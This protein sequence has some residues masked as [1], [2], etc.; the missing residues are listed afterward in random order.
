VT[1]GCAMVLSNM[2]NSNYSRLSE[3]VSAKEWLK[4]K[5]PLCAQVQVQWSACER[6]STISFVRVTHQLVVLSLI[7]FSR[8]RWIIENANAAPRYLSLYLTKFK[9]RFAQVPW[10]LHVG[11]YTTISSVNV[12]TY[13][14]VVSPKTWTHF[15]VIACVTPTISPAGSLYCM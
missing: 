12:R 10:S 3:I 2:M 8:R 4:L 9:E 5:K 1:I 7:T 14:G 11:V 6:R 13:V 15:V